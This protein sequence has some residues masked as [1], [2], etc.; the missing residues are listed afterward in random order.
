MNKLIVEIKPGKSW[1]RKTRYVLQKDYEL[2]GVTVPKDFWTDGASVPRLLWPIFPT[3]GKYA[4]AAVLHDYLIY[5][6]TDRKTA[7]IA[8]RDAMKALGVSR[9]R[10]TAMYLAVRLF[11]V[12]SGAK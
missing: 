6:K 7:D 12:L 11:S 3:M 4:G 10:V 5:K 1:L 9:W 2:N 8:F